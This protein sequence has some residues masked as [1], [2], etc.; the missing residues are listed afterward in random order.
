[1]KKFFGF[2]LVFLLFGAVHGFSQIGQALFL[3]P[4]NGMYRCA[5]LQSSN[6]DA[7][8]APNQSSTVQSVQIQNNNM[9]GIYILIYYTN[10]T[11]ESLGLINPRR[12]TDMDYYTYEVSY[13]NSQPTPGY[14]AQVKVN[15][16]GDYIS[17]YAGNNYNSSGF[18]YLNGPNLIIITLMP[19]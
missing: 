7:N 9:N 15:S 10:G 14:Y 8:A 1:M 2:C 12:Q 5:N 4:N 16:V 17:I 13:I 18:P 6:T 3:T 11:T 19:W